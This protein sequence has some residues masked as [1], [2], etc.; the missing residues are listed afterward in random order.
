MTQVDK[1]S[2]VAVALGQRAQHIVV[3]G[4]GLL[5]FLQTEST[6]NTSRRQ[7]MWAFTLID[8]APLR[9]VIGSSTGKY[10]VTA[11]R[12]I[13][14]FDMLLVMSGSTPSAQVELD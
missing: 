2:M 1:A 7:E 10:G 14:G 11:A 4:S 6:R 3:A 9:P 5:N 8:L 12:V 13:H